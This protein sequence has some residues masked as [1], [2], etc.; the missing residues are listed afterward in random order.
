MLD[1]QPRELLL[2]VTR[3]AMP[4][5]DLRALNDD[6]ETL[7]ALIDNCIG[8][9]D[10]NMHLRAGGGPD[11]ASAAA[12]PLRLTLDGKWRRVVRG[13]ILTSFYVGHCDG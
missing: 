1:S 2:G 11:D 6:I 12:A 8:V 9:S 7:L 13:K 5:Q 3:A 4:V 10:T